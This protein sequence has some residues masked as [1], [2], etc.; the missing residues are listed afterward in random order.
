M[1]FK[2]L[3]ITCL[4]AICGLS[5]NGQA[6]VPILSGGAG[7]FTSTSSGSTV[8]QPMIVPVLTVPIGS[9][10]LIE[11]RESFEEFIA[12]QGNGGPYH[13]QFFDTL[14]YAQVDFFATH[15][16]TITAG[17]FL[18]PFDIYN[19]R[20]TAPW[21]QK[22][23][24][25]PII[26]P[27]GTAQAFID[28]GMLRG[29]LVSRD[30]YQITYVAY[31]SALVNNSKA[32]SQRTS[33]GRVSVF[34]PHARLEAGTSFARLLQNQRMNYEGVFF[35]WQPPAAPLDLKGEYAHSARGQ[36]YWIDAGYRLSRNAGA[37]FSL[38][39]LE[40]LGRIQQ[41]QRLQHGT[42]DSLPGVS[43]RRVDAGADYHFPHEVRL[44]ASYGRQ[45]TDT[46]GTNIW[47]FGITYRFLFPLFPGGSH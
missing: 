22:F 27:I 31:V 3:A 21:L 24:D 28:G 32:G 38:G 46:T 15:W 30:A 14:E 47:E 35:S 41:F 13:A 6:I 25:T 18:T 2:L 34:F 11:S 16:M 19:E 23:Q 26:F 44:L 42:G 45:F 4:A 12:P 1:R 29:A 8:I 33:G 36:G 17:R 43:T 5:A 7:F 39:R 9:R 40:A 10:W 20:M 37:A